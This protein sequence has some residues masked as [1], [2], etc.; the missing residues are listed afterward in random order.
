MRIFLKALPLKTHKGKNLLSFFALRTGEDPI[1][2]FIAGAERRK[3]SIM[4]KNFALASGGIK[5]VRANFFKGA[6]F[7]NAHGQ[8]ISCLSLLCGQEKIQMKIYCRRRAAEREILSV[9]R[10]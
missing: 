2:K 7:K 9:G 3:G 8:K 10:D 4:Q 1:E 6:A 5:K